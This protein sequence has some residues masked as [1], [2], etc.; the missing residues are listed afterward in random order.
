[1]VRLRQVLSLVVVLSYPAACFAA[2]E[3]L[4]PRVGHAPGLLAAIPPG[5]QA[6]FLCEPGQAVP[7]DCP[8][9]GAGS[10]RRLM[11]PRPHD[12]RQER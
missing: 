9:V 5:P 3:I 7:E 8:L 6:A 11:L 12:R 10:Q 4:S 2:A 1:M